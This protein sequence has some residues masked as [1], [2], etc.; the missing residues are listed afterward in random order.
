MQRRMSVL[1]GIVSLMAVVAPAAHADGV[2]P[3]DVI[4]FNVAYTF[5]PQGVVAEVGQSEDTG[6]VG[7]C[8][9]DVGCTGFRISEETSDVGGGVGEGRITLQ[10]VVCVRSLDLRCSPDGETPFTGIKIDKREIDTP[11]YWVD[12]VFV[13]VNVCLWWNSAQDTPMGCDFPAL[14]TE[15]TAQEDSGN[16]VEWTPQELGLTF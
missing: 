11:E 5:G 3:G 13:H 16:L 14:L 10:G 7:I 15:G 1:A 4:P 2:P 9:P 8:D 6:L 12:P